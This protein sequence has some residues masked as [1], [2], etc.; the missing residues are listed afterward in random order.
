ML[1]RLEKAWLR[2]ADEDPSD[3]RALSRTA[4]A[5]PSIAGGTNETSVS[6]WWKPATETQQAALEALAYGRAIPTDL[7]RGEASLL[8]EE[9]GGPASL[10]TE[11]IG[12]RQRAPMQLGGNCTKAMVLT[13]AG[14]VL[15]GVSKRSAASPGAAC[16]R[17]HEREGAE[18]L[19]D[20]DIA[21]WRGDRYSV[22]VS[23]ESSSVDLVELADRLIEDLAG[24]HS[25]N[26]KGAAWIHHERNRGGH[27]HL[28]LAVSAADG[29]VIV[30]Q[31]QM[32]QS[33]RDAVKAIERARSREPSR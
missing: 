18:I 7:T 10:N 32:E 2:A 12:V 6:G 13:A 15:V 31:R 27:D 28:H 22:I 11:R 29:R 14:R 3:A 24:R 1:V 4:L 33:V 20:D 26:F 5:T 21:E 8:I 19:H 9:W 16:A 30:T 23:P 17:Y 25:D